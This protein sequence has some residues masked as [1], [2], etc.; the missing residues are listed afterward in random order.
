MDDGVN[1]S[2]GMYRAPF[3]H[4]SSTQSNAAQGMQRRPLQPADFGSNRVAQWVASH[5]G[6]SGSSNQ[7]VQTRGS[8][9]SSA[10]DASDAIDREEAIRSIQ[11]FLTSDLKLP[12]VT[13]R[14]SVLSG[15]GIQDASAA[16]SVDP[17]KEA[18]ISQ[19][20]NEFM[21]GMPTNGAQPT[22]GQFAQFGFQGS[23]NGTPGLTVDIDADGNTYAMF[24]PQQ[25]DA[26]S[27][28]EALFQWHAE[29]QVPPLSPAPRND[30]GPQS[31]QDGLS[32]R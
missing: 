15:Q 21:S 30:L 16:G 2:F 32:N 8:A 3:Q 13:N 1:D 6:A 4:S 23:S 29:Q 28:L 9:A 12:G 10:S 18:A 14:Q 26:D 19:L 22:A 20:M 11:D 25:N 27:E 5:F 31:L 24:F 17:D 7:P